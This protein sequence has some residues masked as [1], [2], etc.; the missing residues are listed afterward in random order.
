MAGTSELD[1]ST[2][3]LL[4]E[5]AA[6][7]AARLGLQVTIRTRDHKTAVEVQIITQCGGEKI[8]FSYSHRY[9]SPDDAVRFIDCMLGRVSRDS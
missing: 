8:Y 6:A 3:K 4:Q 7:A 5:H 2:L 9:S 1:D